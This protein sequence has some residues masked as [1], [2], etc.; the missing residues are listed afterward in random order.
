MISGDFN[1]TNA[2]VIYNNIAI[3]TPAIAVNLYTNSLLQK[4]SGNNKSYISTAN[5]PIQLE[6]VVKHYCC[7]NLICIIVNELNK[8][9]LFFRTCVPVIL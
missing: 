1:N 5:E 2:T 3:H 4:L 9:L 6:K 7:N 8:C